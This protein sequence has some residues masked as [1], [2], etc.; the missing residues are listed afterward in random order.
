MEKNFLIKALCDQSY[1]VEVSACVYQSWETYN[2]FSCHGIP[3]ENDLLLFVNHCSVTY[4]MKNGEVLCAKNG[5]IVYIPSGKE[6]TL[7]IDERDEKYGCTYG[8]NFLLFNGGAERVF[9]N[10]NSTIHNTDTSTM[11]GLFQKMSV[12][13]DSGSTSYARLHQYFYEII[14]L[15]NEGIRK[16]DINRYAVIKDGITYLENDLSLSLSEREI[17]KM[18]AVSQNYFCR[19][20]K[21]YSGMTPEEYILRARLERAKTA[22]KETPLLVS[23]IAE[24]CGFSDAS[25]FCRL[26]K[27]KTGMSPLEY[28]RL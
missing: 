28:R 23:E 8:I 16:T 11:R 25:Y 1:F 5:D 6:Y 7:T 13:T 26:F 15:L 27:R 24:R 14:A 9:L 22:L 3:K 19:L 2:T 12:I 21:E 20:F 4:K 10:E 17:A 18:C